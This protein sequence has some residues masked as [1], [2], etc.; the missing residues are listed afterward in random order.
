[1]ITPYPATLQPQDWQGQLAGAISEPAALLQALQLPSHLLPAAERAAAIFP[2]RVTRH[3]LSLIR[4]GDEHDPL[5]RQVLPL[6][7]ETLATP[8]YIDDP[9]GDHSARRGAGVLH[10]YRG[11][12][13]LITTGACAIHCRYCF[14]RNYPYAQDNAV[15][16]W[17]AML[18]QLRNMP[19]ISEVILSGGDPLS[20]SD[21]RLQEL[22]GQL[23][24]IPQL[25]RLRIHTRLPLVLPARITPQ[26]L[27]LLRSNRL[28]SSMVL[29]CNHPRELAAAL[30]PGLLALQQAGVALLNQSVLLAG[31][32][33]DADTLCELSERLF[34]LHVLPYYLHL[35]DPV[36][37]AAHF[38]VPLQTAASL[39]QTLRERLPGYLVPRLVREI[40]GAPSKTPIQ[41]L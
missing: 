38:E 36:S 13:L 1:M 40:A 7:A 25:R 21:N 23:Q 29:H 20:L 4:P 17:Q 30:E 27:D 12:A 18:E 2:L 39:Q 31:V 9:V 6:G 32:N 22:I 19:D 37:G 15:R 28:R 3:F 10:K 24:D 34:E 11:R 8:G 16:H 41:L 26:L 33:D 35:L 5:L 14:R